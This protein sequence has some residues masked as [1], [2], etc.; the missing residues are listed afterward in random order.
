MVSFFRKEKRFILAVCITIIGVGLLYPLMFFTTRTYVNHVAGEIS[1]GIQQDLTY[2]L[3]Q[4]KEIVDSKTLHSYIAS[5]DHDKTL[6]ILNEEK[7]NRKLS[8]MV[9]VDKNGIALARTPILSSYGDYIFQTQ[10]WGREAAKGN[11]I[12]QLGRGRTYPLVIIGAYPITEQE[13]VKGA[14]FA[15]YRM[16][17]D[18]ATRFRRAYLE[19]KNDLVFYSTTD[20]VVGHTLTSPERKQMALNMFSPGSDWIQKQLS[21]QYAQIDTG[22]YFIRNIPFTDPDDTTRNVGGVLLLIPLN[23]MYE[24]VIPSLGLALIVF[25][26]ILHFVRKS[27]RFKKSTPYI[28]FGV[29][30]AVLILA[31][32]ANQYLVRQK[33]IKVQNSLYSIYNSTLKLVP[34]SNIYDLTSSQK[35]AIQINTGGEAINAIQANLAYDPEKVTIEDILT[36]N[37]ICPAGNFLEK[38]IDNTKGEVRISCYIVN[39]GFNKDKG[40]IAEILVQPKQIGEFPLTFTSQTQVLANDGLGT[41]VLRETTNGNYS[42]THLSQNNKEAQGLPVFSPTH[43]NGAR[44]YNQKDIKLY[45]PA[46]H[47]TSYAYSIDQSPTST[48][49]INSATEL[50]SIS[51]HEEKDGQYYFHI[52][53]IAGKMVGPATHYGIRIDSTK[54]EPP[55]IKMSSSSIRKGDVVRVELMSKDLGSGLQSNYYIRINDGTLLPTLPQLSIP[56]VEKGSHTLKVRVFDNAGNFS[57][58]TKEISVD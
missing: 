49:D 1:N 36:T 39:P 25:F 52:A 27:K 42:V 35:I 2:S 24:A 32:L 15:G 6:A 20:G 4:A 37:S 51:L 48:P 57:E 12:A 9:A 43:P 29:A 44:W 8:T 10:P 56:F 40:T 11:P 23:F 55:T 30:L 28:A 21:D 14:I 54:P 13:M 53:Q 50:G 31:S 33:T 38:T 19:D 47:G 7:I 41:N 16:D 17:D 18:Y 34:D 3:E 5:G 26:S 22:S 45:W 46:V 58:T